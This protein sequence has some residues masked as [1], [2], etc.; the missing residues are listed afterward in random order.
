MKKRKNED[1]SFEKLIYKISQNEHVLK[2]KN[3]IQHGTTTTYSHSLSVAKT[4]YKINRKLHIGCDEKTLVTAAFLHDFFFMTGTT[5]KSVRKSMGSFT[6][7]LPAITRN[8]I[9]ILTI[10]NRR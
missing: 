8:F 7:K 5:K 1:D 4:S 2:M 9:L 6:L 3:S 10:K